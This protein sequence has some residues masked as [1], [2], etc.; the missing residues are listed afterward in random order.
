MCSDEVLDGLHVVLSRELQESCCDGGHR[1]ES[2]CHGRPLLRLRQ[3]CVEVDCRRSSSA[4]TPAPPPLQLRL[5]AGAPSTSD[6]SADQVVAEAAALTASLTAVVSPPLRPH[7]RGAVEEPKERRR[8][9][10]AL[11]CSRG[12]RLPLLRDPRRIGP[13]EGVRRWP[14]WDPYRTSSPVDRQIPPQRTPPRLQ[15]LR[16]APPLTP[17]GLGRSI[18][19]AVMPRGRLQDGGGEAGGG[20][21]EVARGA[22]G[23][24]KLSV[25]MK[26]G[27]RIPRMQHG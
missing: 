10:C 11:L 5:H 2:I 9:G 3:I 27:E 19:A 22:R 20:A 23:G 12:P 6:V 15:N 13:P 25:G 1:L 7:Q 21:C 8:T 14:P 4:S 26:I 18:W 17:R 24:R 16:R